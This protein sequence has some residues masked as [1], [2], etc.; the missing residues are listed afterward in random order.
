MITAESTFLKEE[1]DNRWFM[2]V[3]GYKPIRFVKSEWDTK[4]MRD[5]VLR[6]LKDLFSEKDILNF[7]PVDIEDFA[8]SAD[9]GVFELTVAEEGVKQIVHV[10]VLRVAGMTLYGMKEA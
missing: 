4:A 10:M 7:K 8:Q 9:E 5:L 6:D 1:A 2:Q 3:H